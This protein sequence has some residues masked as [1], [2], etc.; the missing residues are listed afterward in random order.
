MASWHIADILRRCNIS[1]V[2]EEMTINREMLRVCRAF[3]FGG[4]GSIVFHSLNTPSE[5][6]LWSRLREFRFV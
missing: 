3:F 6:V 1:F 4:Q 2:E 5:D